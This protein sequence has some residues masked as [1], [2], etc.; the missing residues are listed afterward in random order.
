MF[1]IAQIEV[2]DISWMYLN[3]FF[4]AAF[5]ASCSATRLLRVLASNVKISSSP[6]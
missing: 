4:L 2:M 5:L 3:R 6:S 1:G